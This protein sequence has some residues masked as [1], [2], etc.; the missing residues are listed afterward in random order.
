MLMTTITTTNMNDDDGETE[1][2]GLNAG[3][4]QRDP[5]NEVKKHNKI[6]VD[7]ST[8]NKIARKSH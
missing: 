5:T 3:R 4:I 2:C 7:E 6:H 8:F 1:C